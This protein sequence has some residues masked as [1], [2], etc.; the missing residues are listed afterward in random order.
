VSGYSTSRRLA[1]QLTGGLAIFAAIAACQQS[2]GRPTEPAA[3]PPSELVGPQPSIVCPS[4][5]VDILVGQEIQTA[6]TA[7]PG[8][9]TFCL[10]SGVHRISASITPKTGD[11]FVGE[12]GA[13]IDG[14][15]WKTA[16]PNQAAFRAH[17]QDI[18][19]VTIRNLVIRNMPA[20]GIHA[21][22]SGADRWTIEFN[23]VTNNTTGVAAP[24]RSLVRNN[25]I[26]H[27]TGGGYSAFRAVGTTF[28]N[29]EIAYNG[30]E[31]KIVGAT[32]VTF[33]SNFVHHNASDGIWYDADNT[34]SLIEG[35]RVEDNGR[36]GIFYE[37][38]GQGVIRRNVIRRNETNGIFISTS[39]D[40][41]IYENTVEDNFRGIQYFLNCEAVG[42]GT[43]RFD[44]ANN[45]ARDNTIR[46]SAKDGAYA[47]GFAHLSSCTPAQVA[48]YLDG[49]RGLR[50]RGNRYL[51]PATES[52]Y[53]LWGLSS[54]KSWTESL[55]WGPS[56]LKTWREWQ[57]LG[58]DTDGAIAQ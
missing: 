45:L 56:S 19:A 44:L 1:A 37:I 54:L 20:K 52:K 38:S 27:N 58:H 7:R 22:W 46:V 57:A 3:L 53:W 2:D 40:V 28:E 23:E 31:Q 24:N 6:V 29:N 39:K 5:A 12:Y 18:D 32:D 30:S 49:S 21:T 11:V 51:V 13:I 34:G 35:N 25:H 8:N 10:K 17:D 14:T 48:P 16:D 42:G 55:S 43:I 26:H 36:E 4:G 50:F 33:R 15:G 47:S 9:T 41:E